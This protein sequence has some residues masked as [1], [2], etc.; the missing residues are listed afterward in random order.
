ME[1]SLFITDEKLRSIIESFLL[2]SDRPLTVTRINEAIPEVDARVIQ[3]VLV[4]LIDEYR[5]RNCGFTIEEVAKGFQFRTLPAN[6]TWLQAWAKKRPQRFSQAALETLAIIAYRQPI[7]RAELEEIRGVDSGGVIRSLLER[8]VIK[9]IGKRDE[10]GT[11]LI[12]A[13]TDKFLEI[14]NLKN[15]EALPTLEEFHELSKDLLGP[16]LEQLG[17]DDLDQAAIAVAPPLNEEEQ[18]VLGEGSRLGQIDER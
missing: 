18:E 5:L 7:I 1:P 17:F 13:T 2:V 10:P 3:K 9:I 15:L 4:V 14:F 12:Y 8:K 16:E 11:P 6:A